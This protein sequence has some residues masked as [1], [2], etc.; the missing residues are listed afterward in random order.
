MRWLK[1]CPAAA[2]MGLS[3]EVGS[4]EGGGENSLGTHE[5]RKHPSKCQAVDA[6]CTEGPRGGLGTAGGQGHVREGA[7]SG[8]VRSH[9]TAQCKFTFLK[10]LSRSESLFF[11]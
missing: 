5:H 11:P 1:T 8:C 7:F 4:V 6:N 9:V 10:G 3:E 2:F